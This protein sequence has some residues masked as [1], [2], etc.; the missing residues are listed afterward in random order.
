[1]DNKIAQYL[2]K[3]TG[4]VLEKCL[5]NLYISLEKDVELLCNVFDSERTCQ[6]PIIAETEQLPETDIAVED[7]NKLDKIKKRIDFVINT[8]SELNVLDQNGTSYLGS[9]V[10]LMDKKE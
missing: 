9:G 5:E 7:I 8:I 3:D 10:G 4:N 1:M 6:N 2:S